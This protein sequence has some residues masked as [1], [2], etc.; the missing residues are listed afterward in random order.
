M[1]NRHREVKEPSLTMLSKTAEQGAHLSHLNLNTEKL[2]QEFMKTAFP[3]PKTS[4]TG[5][6][7]SPAPHLSVLCCGM[8]SG[9]SAYHNPQG[10]DLSPCLLWVDGP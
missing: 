7:D 6:G 9:S 3:R 10:S 5:P 8:N 2:S 4:G 1:E